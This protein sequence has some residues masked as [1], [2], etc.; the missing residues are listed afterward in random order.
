[1]EPR[2]EAAA[3]LLAPDGAL[4]LHCDTRACHVL[5]VLLDRILGEPRFRAQIAWRRT[6]SHPDSHYY[7]AVHDILLFYADRSHRMNRVH[8]ERDPA[9]ARRYYRYRDPD[10]RAFMS[11]NLTGAGAGPPRSFGERGVLAPPPGRQW[12][13]GPPSSSARQEPRARAW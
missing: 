4:Y 1:M 5:R 2:L 3:R 7:G 10:G 6:T 12:S 11:D 9:M 13:R 8:H